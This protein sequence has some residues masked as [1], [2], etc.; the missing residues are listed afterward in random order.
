[1]RDGA[2]IRGLA[3]LRGKR[4]A[5]MPEGSGSYLLFEAIRD[6]FGLRPGTF[7]PLLMPSKRAYAALLAGEVDAVF[8]VISRGNPATARLLASGRVSL[9]PV[10]QVQ[11]LRL[12]VPYLEESVLPRGTYDGARPMPASDVPVIGVRA[13][14]LAR[15]DVPDEVAQAVT[16]TLFDFRSELV[17]TYPRA[18]QLQLPGPQDAIGLPFHPGATAYYDQQKPGFVERYTDQIGLFFS[19][20]LAGGSGLVQLRAWLVNRRKN[21]ADEYNLE[22]LGVLE[23]LEGQPSRTDLESARTRLLEVLKRVVAALDR[24]QI[25]PEGFQSFSFTWEAAMAQLR[26]RETT[27]AA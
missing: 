8:R 21:R 22:L 19:L 10:D 6:H 2:G 27:L 24:D 20:A 25:S 1:V 3:D 14:L 16:G 12:S 26:H 15:S 13:V 5:L 18:A 23:L 4:V 17:E 11:S 7:T 9:V